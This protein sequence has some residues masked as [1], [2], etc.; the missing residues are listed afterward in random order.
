MAGRVAI[1]TGAP[2]N[3]KGI[4]YEIAV[5]LLRKEHT[6]IATCRTAE[7]VSATREQ[8]RREF[9]ERVEVMQL[10]V[11]DS[12]ACVRLV[13]EVQQRYG[14]IDV[15]VNNAGGHYDLGVACSTVDAEQMSDALRINLLGVVA[16]T[17]AVLPGMKERKFGRIVN[18]TSQGGSFTHSWRN[19]PA[20]A[21]SKCATNMYTSVLGTELKDTNIKVNCCCPGWVNTRMGGEKAPRTPAEGAVTPVFL[22]ELP[23][24]GPNGEFFLDC[25]KTEW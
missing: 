12:A 3:K 16:L 19:A 21:V 11:T 24:D 22:A 14:K 9:G 20:Y 7:D 5:L 15:L 2:C 10:D 1:V 18:V 17:H 6:V 8:L 23:D 25:K 4:G 13:Q